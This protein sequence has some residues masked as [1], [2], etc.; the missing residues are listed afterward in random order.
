MNTEN[1]METAAIVIIHQSPQ[2][3][4]Y[5]SIDTHGEEE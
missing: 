1:A 3:V 5:R 4:N 2:K